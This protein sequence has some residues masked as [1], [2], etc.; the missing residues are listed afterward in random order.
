MSV[1]EARSSCARHVTNADRW[2]GVQHGGDHLKLQQ[3]PTL[4]C[5]ESHLHPAEVQLRFIFNPDTK[6]LSGQKRK[7]PQCRAAVQLAPQDRGW[8]HNTRST[9]WLS[10]SQALIVTTQP[11]LVCIRVS[12]SCLRMCISSSPEGS[13]STGSTFCSTSLQPGLKWF[14]IHIYI[15]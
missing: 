9:V 11:L 13:R 8:A 3:W 5:C 10:P 1:Y 7:N 15:T 4:V 12:A 2:C 14:C 6:M